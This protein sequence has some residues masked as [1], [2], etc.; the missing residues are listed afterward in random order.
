MTADVP[1]TVVVEGWRW[2]LH[3]YAIV[4]QYHLVELARR[5]GL[6]LFHR[7]RPYYGAK[8]TPLRGLFP[9]DAEATIAAVPPPPPGLVPDIVL[10]L[11]VPYDLSAAE[12][13]ATMVFVT[14][15]MGR[16][17]DE[18][19]VGKRPA[20]AV[21][22]ETGA[23]I[24]TPS[25]WSRDGL[26]RTGVDPDR[27]F[28]VPHGVDP[29]CFRPASA[30]RRAELRARR[31]W[32]GR[33]VLLNVG[34]MTANKGVAEAIRAVARLAPRHPEL[35]MVFK[36]GDHTYRSRQLF[37]EVLGALPAAQRALV[38]ERIVYDGSTLGFQ[39]MAELYQA[40][41]CYVSP[42]SAE[43]F[44]MPVLEAAACGLPAVCTAGGPT[45]DF[46]A[47]GFARRIAARVV[48][49]GGGYRHLRI[50]EDDLEACLSAVIT[51]GA[52]RERARFTG[53]RHVHGGFSWAAVTEPLVAAL[54]AAAA[55][56]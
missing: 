35:L 34:A 1:L 45:D 2:V 51:D 52:W 30:E 40:A 28:V 7:D 55:R 22:R 19:V 36:G 15:D 31:G 44:N 42:Y 21:Q 48:E 46:V 6:R 20:A 53:P 29:A 17:P 49:T 54:R 18:M 47:D 26:V 56:N 16:L 12:A 37:S 39:E 33:F 50:E 4:N 27:V 43:G 41:D 25:R 10:R 24:L 32:T 3:S 38:A 14:A 9:A 23:F 11:T 8:W 13:G 5:P